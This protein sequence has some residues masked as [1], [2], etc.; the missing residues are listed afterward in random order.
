MP[1]ISSEDKPA[2][3]TASPSESSGFSVNIPLLQ[4]PDYSANVLDLFLESVDG[5]L[6][7]DDATTDIAVQ[8]F[9]ADGVGLP[10]HL[11]GE[12]IEGAS[13]RIPCFGFHQLLEMV[14]MTPQ[15]DDLLGDVGTFRE[16]GDFPDHIH[17]VAANTDAQALEASLTPHRIRL[18]ATLTGGLGAGAPPEVAEY[19]ETAR[20]RSDVDRMVE[21]REKTGVAIG[22]DAV[23]PATGETIPIWTADYVLMGYGTGAI[24]AVPGHDSRDFEFARRFDL[25]ITEVVD[26]RSGA[27][28]VP[29]AEWTEARTGEGLAVN[30]SNDRLQLDGLDTAAAK[31]RVIEWLEANG[32]GR[33]HVSGRGGAGYAPGRPLHRR[34]VRRGQ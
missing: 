27:G 26:T 11:L 4:T 34:S 18:G 6:D 8:T 15:P 2:S 21:S 28:D 30:S 31:T 29:V 24:M 32:H 13:H 1:A 22:I 7:Q 12:E 5:A 9:A 10:K 14:E 3:G 23:N 33:G 19:V 20:N 17:F 25:P 16:D